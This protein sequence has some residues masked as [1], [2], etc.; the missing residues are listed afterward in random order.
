MNNE[1]Q[2]LEYVIK[3]YE[4]KQY[5][6]GLKA[7]VDNEN[8]ISKKYYEIIK[9][10]LIF[11]INTDKLIDASILVKEELSVP[12]IPQDF[13]RFLK[14][15]LKEINFNLRDKQRHNLSMEDL[16]NIDKVDNE[17][18]LYLIP[19]L[20]DFNL[21]LLVEKFQNIFNND[22]IK[23]LVKSLLIASLSDYKLDANFTI[24]KENTLVKFNPKTVFDVRNGDNFIYIEKELSL[25]ENIEINILE[26]I[27]RLVIT[28]LLNIYPLVIGEQYCDD[29]ITAS[30]MLVQI[31]ANT[32][33]KSDKYHKNYD[34][35][36]QIIDKICEKMNI[37]L[38]SI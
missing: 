20:K 17:S 1:I 6:E 2:L 11:L 37:L 18:L 32:T 4:S 10:K 28:Y 33:I 36:R 5:K 24:T 16:E 21:S 8:L 13:E 30:I 15:K 25:L 9:Y 7:I 31:M 35:R 12:Y 38:E 19:H 3:C 22:E 27:K 29:I 34:D 14:E 26:L 23:D